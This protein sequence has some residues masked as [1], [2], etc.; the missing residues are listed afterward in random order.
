MSYSE[1]LRFDL[2]I[3][4]EICDVDQNIRLVE[5]R[6]FATWQQ[7][8]SGFADYLNLMCLDF[9]E[10]QEETMNLIHIVR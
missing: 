7:Q 5:I 1:Y 6:A 10:V 9:S 4:A 2:K 8:V 3:V